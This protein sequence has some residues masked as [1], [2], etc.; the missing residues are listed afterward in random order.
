MSF[1]PIAEFE[2][3]ADPNA[4]GLS[5][6]LAT[7]GYVPRSGVEP[8]TPWDSTAT[9]R[10][11]NEFKA[12][13]SFV[14]KMQELRK[15]LREQLLWIQALQAEQANRRR[16]PAPEFKVGDMVMLDARNIKTTRPNKSLDHKNLGPFEIVRV[17]NNSAY[18]LKLPPAMEGIFP[19][20]HP[21]LLHLD[22]SAPLQGQRIPPPPPVMIDQEGEEHWGV[23]EILDSKIDRRRNDPL[24]GRKGCLMY[25]IRYT[26][27]EDDR[28]EWEPYPNTAGCPA[29]VADY[30]HQYPDKPGPHQSFRTPQDWEPLLAML[31]QSSHVEPMDPDPMPEDPKSR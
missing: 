23:Q 3:N 20:F 28:P 22:N 24:T 19:V 7:K 30:H 2:A 14:I 11:K 5:P 9:Q 31:L 17:I 12:A 13:D 16:H 27:Y 21:W 25:K 26:G 15:Y 8:P 18:E 6:F 29:L 10:A 1:L 4:S